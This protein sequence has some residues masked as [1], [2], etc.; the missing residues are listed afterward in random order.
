[1]KK[2]LIL[3]ITIMMSLIAC[4]ESNNSEGIGYLTF[5]LTYEEFDHEQNSIFFSDIYSIDLQNQQPLLKSTIPY[6]RDYPLGIYYSLLDSIIYSG[7]SVDYPGNQVWMKNLKDDSLKRL[8]DNFAYLVFLQPVSNNLL[9]VGGVLIGARTN[10]VNLFELNINTGQQIRLDLNE[11]ID[12]RH[13][14]FNAKNDS[15][16]F[17]G[18]SYSEL[19]KRLAEQETVPFEMSENYV[20]E[21]KDGLVRELFIFDEEILALF[22]D[23]DSLYYRTSHSNTE[24]IDIVSHTPCAGIPEHMIDPYYDSARRIVY[25]IDGNSIKSYD[26]LTKRTT[27]IFKSQKELSTINNMFYVGKDK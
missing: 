5:T 16:V 22:I 1:M 15:L 23:E 9:L 24:C 14:S 4:N 19:R 10:A 3:L 2:R 13:L 17:V 18:Y 7:I 21:Y 12:V 20:F 11:D 26:F 25:Y 27:L 6:E 8:T